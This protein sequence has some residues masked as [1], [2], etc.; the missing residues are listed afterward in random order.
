MKISRS[1]V[2]E[3]GILIFII[4]VYI[5]FRW[6]NLE[7]FL[8]FSADQGAHFLK[9]FQLFN[10]RK[11]E[12]V[13]PPISLSYVGKYI[14]TSSIYYYI[15]MPILIISKWDPLNSSYLLILLGSVMVIPLYIGVKLLLGRRQAIFVSTL[16]AILPFYIDY[17]RFFWNPNLQ[18]ILTPIL[19]Y[20]IGLYARSKKTIFLFL[21]SFCSGV[22][23]LFHYQYFLIMFGLI[24]YYL[25]LGEKLSRKQTLLF[26]FG[27]ILGFSPML[28]FELRNNFYN[29]QTLYLYIGKGSYIF[30]KTT[31]SIIS[32]PHYVL[33]SSLFILIIAIHIL[34]KKIPAIFLVA[35]ILV[36]LLN[37][38][39]TYS[40]IPSHGFGMAKDWN[41]IMEIKTHE[42][43]KSQHLKNYNIV[44]LG[45]DSVAV[46]QKY[47][48]IKDNIN[49]D[50]DDYYH[51]EYLF[52]ITDGQNY[53]KNP[54]YEINTFQPNSI[55]SSWPLN[56]TYRLILLK[57][58]VR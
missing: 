8:N 17:S 19:I 50:F 57:R 56:R 54:A 37:S 45:Y 25:F 28:L 10:D 49:G 24:I 6:I 51:N 47:L 39:Y 4:F 18:F 46:V 33:S 27:F 22:L 48:L 20:F 12:L 3:F 2:I 42:I 34:F 23:L 26:L 35:T 1:S 53:M 40:S 9:V 32:T 43:I 11:I 55:V 41:Y 44:N 58:R 15:M 52:L 14:F 29:L 36:I 7:H 30:K 31:S 16:F 21:I 5:F 38:F 13:G